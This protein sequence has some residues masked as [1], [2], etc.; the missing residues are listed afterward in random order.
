M[1]RRILIAEDE[2]AIR[3]LLQA[4]FTDEGYQ[5]TTVCDGQ[6]GLET[7]MADRFDLVLSNVAM[8]RLDGRGLARAMHDAPTL[9]SVPIILM[10]AAG[11]TLVQG[12]P[13]ATFIPK[14]FDLGHVLDVVEQILATATEQ[15]AK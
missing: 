11:A 2:R 5:V 13:H 1:P 14:P 12:V 7:L 15:A 9:R 10:S 8:P 6:E 3:E 4:V